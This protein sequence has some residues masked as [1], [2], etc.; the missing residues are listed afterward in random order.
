ME[1]HSSHKL[2]TMKGEGV[3]LREAEAV[4]VVLT[5]GLDTEK[6]RMDS[7]PKGSWRFSAL[8]TA[9]WLCKSI[10]SGLPFCH[11]RPIDTLTVDIAV[12][13]EQVSFHVSISGTGAVGLDMEAHAAALGAAMG[14]MDV[15][16]SYD[17]TVAV[18]S[19]SVVK[20]SS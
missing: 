8:A 19:C 7:F 16:R 15:L 18:T 14:A 3:R 6:L 10:A 5:H 20:R 13:Q 1:T 12:E 9:S 2:L 17:P 4:S 11:P